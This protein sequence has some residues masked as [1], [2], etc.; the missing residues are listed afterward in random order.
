MARTDYASRPPL[1]RLFTPEIQYPT[2]NIADVVI[3]EDIPLEKEG[4]NPI[5]YGTPRP[6]DSTA[7]L[8]WQ[9]PVKAG[10][11]EVLHRRVWATTRGAQEAYNAAIQYAA[12]SV[13]HPVYIRR[14]VE[15][16]STYAPGTMGAALTAIIK[17]T[18]TNGGS[19]YPNTPGAVTASFSGG[20]GTGAAA[21]VEVQ[22]G[23][24]VAVLI[25][26]GGSGYTSAPSVAFSAATGS[27]GAATT[28]I[29][30]TTALLVDAES[31]PA[32][33]ELA[34]LF[35]QVTRVY[36]TL[37]GPIITSHLLDAETQTAVVVTT[38]EVINPGAAYAQ[39]GGSIIEYQPV[40]SVYG[41]KVTS[42]L[43]NFAS[44]TRTVDDYQ[45]FSFPKL[46]FDVFQQSMRFREGAVR[47]AI[48]WYGK[49]G[50]PAR[51]AF[52][53]LTKISSEIKYYAS[54]AD[55]DA[56]APAIEYA[57]IFNDLVYDGVFFNANERGVLNDEVTIGPFTTGTENPTTGYWV[58]AAIT[59][60]EST[61][62]AS[63]Y[64]D[65]V[66]D[67]DPVVIGVD[68]KPW[69]YNLWR[70]VISRVVLR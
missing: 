8:V 47:T 49:S 9:G 39:S 7:M 32:E 37:P 42:T 70:M 28:A 4:F 6:D 63:E 19:G 51:N 33:G 11:N 62:S 60:N 67:G 61:P 59:F 17:I 58:E 34:S 13:S 20:G 65:L 29:Q 36:R 69:K 31:V 10:N 15:P 53:A 21:T 48:Y 3:V 26:N 27:S 2:P 55:A 40:N 66:T 50:A 1:T 16:R 5:R 41:R 35:L 38:Q 30:P 24:I 68:I 57:P 46:I 22:S 25:T 56:A 45:M 54:K 44:V 12:A 14:S 43:S 23:V 18:V 64:D 52:R